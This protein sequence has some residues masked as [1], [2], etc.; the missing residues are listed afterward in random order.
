MDRLNHS[1]YQDLKAQGMDALR[2][3]EPEGRV[4]QIHQ[5]LEKLTGNSSTD[6]KIGG[7]YMEEPGA[8]AL[9]EELYSSLQIALSEVEADAD[10]REELNDLLVYVKGD[11]RGFEQAI[12]R[13]RSSQQK[14][15]ILRFDAGVNSSGNSLNV[16][17]HMDRA[18]DRVRSI[19]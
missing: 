8:L 3:D 13:K 6:K 19:L 11:M 1:T 4:F 16:A 14:N 2:I 15:R 10:L 18:R 5:T 12:E 17:G 9:A 7:G